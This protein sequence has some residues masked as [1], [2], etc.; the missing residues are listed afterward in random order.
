MSILW[1]IAAMQKPRFIANI[2]S[3]FRDIDI[4]L[5]EGIFLFKPEYRDH[6][7]LKIWI[8]CSFETALQRAMARGQEGL[9]PA[10]TRRA[11]ETIYFPAQRVHFARDNPREFADIIFVNDTVAPD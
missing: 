2:V 4:V 10:E 9:P 5:L 8:E 11:F 1:P 7:D 3:C 6:F